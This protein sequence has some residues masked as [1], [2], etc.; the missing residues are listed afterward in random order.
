M[1]NLYIY[2]SKLPQTLQDLISEYN[3]EHRVFYM[4]VMKELK[5]SFFQCNLCKKIFRGH[6]YRTECKLYSYIYCS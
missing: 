1:K 6:L 5:S 3:V 4:K 2:I